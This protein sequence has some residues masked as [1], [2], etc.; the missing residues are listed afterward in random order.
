LI[1]PPIFG[2]G[3]KPSEQ[4]SRGKSLIGTCVAFGLLRHFAADDLV[5]NWPL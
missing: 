1:Q 2:T 5:Q 3:Q 4:L